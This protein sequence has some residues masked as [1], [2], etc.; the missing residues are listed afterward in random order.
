MSAPF[1]HC[2]VKRRI[3]N[4]LSSLMGYDTIV[5]YF[6]ATPTNGIDLLNKRTVKS[7][8][9]PHLVKVD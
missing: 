8:C 6:Y 7:K 5:T 9:S 3:R 2:I 4:E 1:Y